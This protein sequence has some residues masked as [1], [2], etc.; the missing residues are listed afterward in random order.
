MVDPS[1]HTGIEFGE[2][3]AAGVLLF[4]S[5]SQTTARKPDF[6][7]LY[8]AVG[9]VDHKSQPGST[10]IHRRYLCLAF[11]HYQTVGWAKRSAPISY[12]PA[13]GLQKMLPS[14]RQLLF[15]LLS[16]TTARS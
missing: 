6:T 8:P 14:K 15:L 3:D 9:G 12:N 5:L 13:Y 4:V 7:R 11:V 10:V 2:V 16:L 1:L